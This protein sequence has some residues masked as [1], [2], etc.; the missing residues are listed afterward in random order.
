MQAF[1]CNR[2]SPQLREMMVEAS[3]ALARMDAER[4]EE[5]ALFCQ[6]LDRDL[7]AHG[8]A[9]R[10]L[11]R[12]AREALGE[13]AVLGRVLDATRANLEVM[14]RLRERSRG[15]REYS[16]RLAGG[17]AGTCAPVEKFDGNH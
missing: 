13:M 2:N 16:G 3:L 17:A 14:D 9:K 12:M 10:G 11:E 4:L 6:A 7:A 8:E 1:E 5:L 15:R